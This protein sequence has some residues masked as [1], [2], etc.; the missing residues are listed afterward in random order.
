MKF[1][2]TQ[3]GLTKG[4]NELNM[5]LWQCRIWTGLFMAPNLPATTTPN[6]TLSVE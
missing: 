6:S 5:L 1:E 4:L 2:N 3:H